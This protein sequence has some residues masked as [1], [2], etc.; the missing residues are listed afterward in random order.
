MD[1]ID[2][3][4]EVD[5]VLADRHPTKYEHWRTGLHWTGLSFLAMA[6]GV[7]LERAFGIEAGGDVALGGM[8]VSWLGIGYATINLNGLRSRD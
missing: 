8:G 4:F 5:P 6:G 7:A 3:F 2:K 1:K